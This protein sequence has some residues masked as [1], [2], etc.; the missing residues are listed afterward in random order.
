MK[1]KSTGSWRNHPSRVAGLPVGHR[2]EG[3]LSEERFALSRQAGPC[4][5]GST[6]TE[7]AL[8]YQHW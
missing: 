5:S 4:S 2:R 6:Q 7:W 1:Q 3:I 8:P